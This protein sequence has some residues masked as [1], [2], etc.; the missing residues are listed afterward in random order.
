[1]TTNKKWLWAVIAILVIS[2]AIAAMELQNKPPQQDDIPQQQSFD[3]KNPPFIF[4]TVSQVADD[5]LQFV[6]GGVAYTAQITSDTKLTKQISDPQ[7]GIK[8]VDANIAD[9]ESGSEIAVYFGT[10][11][12]GNLYIADKIQII[13][14]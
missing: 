9:F 5:S 3:P 11:A 14:Q 12:E 2:A 4:G 8:T 13:S 1:M 10:P 6:A 7:V